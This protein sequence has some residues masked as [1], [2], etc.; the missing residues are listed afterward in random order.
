MQSGL[1]HWFC[2]PDAP[3]SA[4]HGHHA[5]GTVGALRAVAGLCEGWGRGRRETSLCSTSCISTTLPVQKNYC[6]ALCGGCETR[7]R[8]KCVCSS[9]VASQWAWSLVCLGRQS[10]TPFQDVL[11]QG[12]SVHTQLF[13]MCELSR[14][15]PSPQPAPLSQAFPL[16]PAP[17]LAITSAPGLCGSKAIFVQVLALRLSQCIPGG[18]RNPGPLSFPCSPS[19]ASGSSSP[20]PAF[21]PQPL[22][23]ASVLPAPVLPVLVA[24]TLRLGGVLCYPLNS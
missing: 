1:L 4:D 6:S 2:V 5:P 17:P 15:S 24:C 14:M 8:V 22:S 7:V 20:L 12:V 23:H 16:S 18:L 19:Q 9:G 10:R 11:S 13:R 21:Q 3:A